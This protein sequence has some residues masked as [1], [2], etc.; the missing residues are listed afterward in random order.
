MVTGD[1]PCVIPFRRML[2]T[3]P[4]WSRMPF[5]AE[6]GAGSQG[7]LS[8]GD[9]GSFYAEAVT[10]S[11]FRQRPESA[12]RCLQPRPVGAVA[13]GALAVVAVVVVVEVVLEVVLVVVRRA[14]RRP[15]GRS[16]H[17]ARGGCRDS[18]A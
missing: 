17:S 12:A 5:A 8:V 9:D 10:G 6:A 16:R 18:G 7:H 11:T 1:T 14:L 3:P 13:T 15:G 2:S 4:P